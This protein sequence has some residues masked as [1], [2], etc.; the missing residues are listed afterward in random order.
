M[1][2]DESLVELALSGDD[3]AFTELHHRYFNQIFQYAYSQLGDYHQAEELTQDIFL[4]MSKNLHRFKYR[5]KFRTWLY[6]IGHN[7]TIDYHRKNK[8]HQ[9]SKPVAE[10]Y[11][12]DQVAKGEPSAEDKVM[13]KSKG[14]QIRTCLKLLPEHYRSV[15]SLR[16]LQGFSIAETAEVMSKT[17]AA[18][19]S[20]Q[21]R[22][23]D[24]FKEE[25]AK[26]VTHHEA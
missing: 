12:F 13:G 3:N 9:K 19:K 22:A 6:S 5:S 21:K 17:P 23:M 24:S 1:V 8:K 16:F 20:L 7:A 14:D 10:N 15:I 11:Y 26:E 2:S 25:L 18:I 4:K